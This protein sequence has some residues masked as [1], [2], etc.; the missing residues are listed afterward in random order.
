MA[1]WQVLFYLHPEEL[2]LELLLID[3]IHFFSSRKTHTFSWSSRRQE[4]EVLFWI[5]QVCLVLVQLQ[6]WKWRHH[7]EF[8]KAESWFRNIIQSGPV[9]YD[10]LK[11]AGLKDIFL[12]PLPLHQVDLEVHLQANLSLEIQVKGWMQCIQALGRFPSR[13]LIKDSPHKGTSECI[14]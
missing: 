11:V 13:Y 8:L 10:A 1:A 14:K 4:A 5:L 3:H 9:I 12:L 6:R 7:G 2:H